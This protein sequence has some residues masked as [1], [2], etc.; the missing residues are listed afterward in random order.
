M[1]VSPSQVTVADAGRR[2][3]GGAAT[4]EWSGLRLQG[5]SSL[6]CAAARHNGAGKT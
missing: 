1:A 3:L 5:A 2:E 6:T 4:E